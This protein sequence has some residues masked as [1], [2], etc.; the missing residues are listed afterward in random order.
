VK[1]YVILRRRAWRTIEDLRESAKRAESAIER[2]PDDVSWIRSYLLAES[3]G[4]VGTVCVYQATSPEAVRAHAARAGLPV[5]EIVAVAEA[6][7]VDGYR[8]EAPTA[9]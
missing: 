8:P 3:D 5:D 4:S 9:A 7:V 2:T 6:L 1:T